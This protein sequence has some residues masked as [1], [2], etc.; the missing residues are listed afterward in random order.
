[1]G[2]YSKACIKPLEDYLFAGNSQISD[3]LKGLKATT[4]AYPEESIQGDSLPSYFNVNTPK[5]Y[6]EIVTKAGRTWLD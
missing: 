4:Y 3:F 6:S 1:L 2:V 5:D